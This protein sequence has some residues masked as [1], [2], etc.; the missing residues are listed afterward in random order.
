[1]PDSPTP[2]SPDAPI[3]VGWR[4]WIAL[5]DLGL[6][7]IRCKVDTGAA[8]S[9]LHAVGVERFERDGREWARFRVRPFHRRRR[10]VEVTGEAPLVDEREVTSSS[11][12]AECRLVVEV[13]LRLGLRADAPAWLVELTLTNRGTMRFPMLLGR[14][15]MEG[16]VHVD[17]GTSYLLGHLARPQ[18]FYE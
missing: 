2:R 16:R 13:S 7:A 14:Q 5:P 1:M 9:S 6:L 10:H 15:A 4:E 17:P 18:D 8:T 3:L 11:G 12:H